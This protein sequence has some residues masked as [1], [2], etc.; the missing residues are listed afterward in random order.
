[1]LMLLTHERCSKLQAVNID[2][3]LRGSGFFA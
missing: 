2:E 3:K 1:M